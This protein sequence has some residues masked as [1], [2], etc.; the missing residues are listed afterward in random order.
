MMMRKVAQTLLANK[1]FDIEFHGYLSNH[2][3]HA[4]V[5]LEG[6]Q[7]P[8][9]RVQE[10]WDEYTLLT[11]YRLP[12]HKVEEEWDSVEP[13]TLDEWNAWRGKKINWQNQVVFMSQQLKEKYD[14]DTNSLVKAFAPSL[15]SGAAGALT[16]GIIHLGWAIDAQSPWMIA[17]G[18]AY[19]NFAYLGFNNHKNNKNKETTAV[20]SYNKH[21]E[22]SPMD[23]YLRVARTFEQEGLQESWIE[24]VKAAYD[25]SFHPELVQAGFQWQLA[26]ALHEP[27]AV[28]TEL[29]TWLEEKSMQEL[30]E[31]LYTSVV[32]VYLATRSPE[33]NGNFV[34]L[35]LITALWGL[36]KTL[37]VLELSDETERKVLGE[38]Y[39]LSVVLLSMRSDGFPSVLSL[40]Q[41]QRNFPQNGQSTPADTDWSVVVKAAI[42]ETEEHNI[43]LVYVARELWRRYNYW[44]GFYEAAKS[45]T[46]TP[47]IGPTPF[48][49]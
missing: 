45:F 16:H 36:E 38:F 5:A 11:P 29:P 47:Q 46:L 2:S 8:E 28:A 23:S 1:E 44:S 24:R 42:A 25:N 9:A 17:E 15:V 14:N 30:W 19:L 3:K 6:L 10:Y 26:K 37:R 48:Q 22:S 43:K 20:F 18:L 21:T 4:V 32:F 40:E 12:L 27:H 7:A 34:V 31:D 49:D 39:A 35:H 41:V 13:A 33:G